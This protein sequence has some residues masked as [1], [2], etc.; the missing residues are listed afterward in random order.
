MLDPIVEPVPRPLTAIVFDL[1]GTLVN[2]HD[3]IA[4]TVNRVLSQRRHPLVDPAVVHAMTGLPLVDIF[5]SVLPPAEVES[6]LAC[7]DTYR[8]IFDDEVLPAIEPIPGAVEAVE[9]LATVAPLGVATGRLT[10][11][12]E[13]M[14]ARCRLAPYFGAVVGMDLVP[15]PKPFPDVLLEALRRMGG[16][17]PSQVLVVGDSGADIAVA[18]AAGARC[19]AVTWGTQPREALL[20]AELDWC[21]DRWQELAAL[22]EHAWSVPTA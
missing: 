10:S 15:R 8:V 5:R 21:I 3:L 16:I 20:A 6:A 9:A 11:T 17:E 22:V 4:R 2:S 13:R 18:R 19:C 14:L 12:A 1:D 7:V